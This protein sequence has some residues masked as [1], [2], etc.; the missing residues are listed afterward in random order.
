MNNEKII[1][2]KFSFHKARKILSDGKLSKKEYNYNVPADL[3]RQLKDYDVMVSISKYKNKPFEKY[4][5][6]AT[7]IQGHKCFVHLNKNIVEAIIKS[8]KLIK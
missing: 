5:L 1:S 8:W 3:E 7:Q 4:L 6:I 2:E